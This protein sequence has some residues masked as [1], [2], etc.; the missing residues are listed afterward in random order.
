MRI[1]GSTRPIEAKRVPEADI[2][3]VV[4][5]WAECDPSH[6][7]SNAHHNFI[8]SFRATGLGKAETF[9][10]DE[11]IAM[12]GTRCDAALIE[13]V[14]TRRPDIVFAT[15]VRGTDMNPSIDTLVRIGNETS[16]RI[17]VLNGDSYD[18]AAILWTESFASVA[19][20]IVVQ[21]CYSYYPGRV[22]DPRKY[23]ATWTPQDPGLFFAGNDPR[24]IDVSFLGS[25]GRYPDRKRALGIIEAA[26]LNV[27]RGGGQAEAALSIEDYAAVLRQSRIVL[28]FSRP[29]F[30]ADIFQCKGRVIEATLSG[31]LLFEQENPETERWLTS[32]IHHVSFGDE[33]DLLDKVKYYLAHEDERAAMALAGQ[34]H[35]AKNLSA[36]VYWR[37]VIAAASHAM[38]GS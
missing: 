10:F 33:R 9:F 36:D 6:G 37:K 8:A 34:T 7:L 25:V 30:D 11:H 12:N 19:D 14:R 28:N 18:D 29:V 2:L 13:C 1:F 31:A 23:L 32:G 17:V 21:D 5:K 26:G 20:V 3:F 4:E 27:T 22:R 16:A 15:P 38:G 35:A 24:P